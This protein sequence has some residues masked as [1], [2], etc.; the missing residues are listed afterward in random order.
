MAGAIGSF[1][2]EY[3]VL[4]GALGLVAFVGFFVWFGSAFVMQNMKTNRGTRQQVEFRGKSTGAW[5]DLER[6]G[7]AR[8]NESLWSTDNNKWLNL[9][10]EIELDFAALPEL[11][12]ALT[13]DK[14]KRLAE[15]ALGKNPTRKKVAHSWGPNETQV[16]TGP[17]MEDLEPGFKS[18]NPLI[19]KWAAK[20][21]GYWEGKKE[22][23]YPF[24]EEIA[25]NEDPDASKAAGDAIEKL[26]KKEED[27]EERAK[28]RKAKREAKRKS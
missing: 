13:H 7:K 20:M 5:L 11:F 26:K 1:L 28:A 6:V 27:A 8:R 24:L 18:T 10:N 21:A 12:Q 9:D 23:M 16:Y 3:Q 19:L 14:T 4:A 22:D 15:T 17:L 25:K 2:S